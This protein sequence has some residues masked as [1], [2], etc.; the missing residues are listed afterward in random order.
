MNITG[1]QKNLFLGFKE[2]ESEYNVS[3]R[4]Q[5]ASHWFFRERDRTRTSAQAVPTNT[6]D[7]TTHRHYSRVRTVQWLTSIWAAICARA[8]TP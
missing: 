3:E 2:P 7:E 8:T 5:K 6:W 4:S 1:K